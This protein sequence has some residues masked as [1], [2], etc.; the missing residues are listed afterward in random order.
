MIQVKYYRKPENI[1]GVEYFLDVD[2]F[3]DWL[4]LV[5]GLEDEYYYITH[6]EFEDWG[7]LVLFL[8]F[9]RRYKV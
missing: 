7:L 1:R 5:V 2:E 6:I 8:F 3:N 4:R 9:F